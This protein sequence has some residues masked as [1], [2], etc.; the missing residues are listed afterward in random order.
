MEELIG[1]VNGGVNRRKIL[2]ILA[3]QGANDAQRIAKIARLIPSA[4]A[5]ILRDLESRELVKKDGDKFE[6]TEQGKAVAEMTRTL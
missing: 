2:D 5:T 3:S 6:L 1:F 4:T